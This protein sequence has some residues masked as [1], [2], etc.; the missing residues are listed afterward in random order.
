MHE[1]DKSFIYSTFL[2]G[3][4]YGNP[5]Y[6][7]INKTAFFEHYPKVLDHILSKQD[8]EVKVACLADDEDIILG[9]AIIENTVLHYIAVKESWRMQGIARKLLAGSEIATVT[10]STKPGASII[11]KKGWELNPWK[12]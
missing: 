8:T 10:H 6:G 2:R 4:Y 3:L 5:F 9:Y 7:A 11:K 12:I 1:G